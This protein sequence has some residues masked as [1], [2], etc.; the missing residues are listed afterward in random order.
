MKR[1]ALIAGVGLCGAVVGW[2]LARAATLRALAEAWD[3]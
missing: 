2:A 1:A 3:G